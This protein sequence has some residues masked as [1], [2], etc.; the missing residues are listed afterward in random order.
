MQNN[1]TYSNNLSHGGNIWAKSLEWGIKPQHILDFSASINPL[2][3]SPMAIEAI[4]EYLP[5]LQHYPDPRAKEFKKALAQ[6]LSI[7]KKNLLLGNGSIELIYTISQALYKKRIIKLAPSFSEY[8]RGIINPNIKEISLEAEANFALPVDELV[9]NIVNNDLIFI[10]NPHNPSGKLFLKDELIDVLKRAKEIGA[11]LIIDEAF[12][13]FSVDRSQSM[14]DLINEYHNLIVLGSMT[15]FFAL[16]GLRLGY[17]VIA[18]EMKKLL[19]QRLP[20]WRV[21]T[22]ALVAGEASL[23]DKT[24]IKKSRD[25]INNEKGFL[26]NALSAINT[27]EIYDSDTNFILINAFKSGKS[28]EEM[29]EELK[30]SA[31]LIRNCSS[32]QGLTPNHFRIAVRRNHENIKLIDRLRCILQ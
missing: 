1:Y 2:G 13:D 12:M 21:N 20:P 25:L 28:S 8:G 18:N 4:L 22:L 17:A 10:N 9:K 30:E 29:Q 27:L 11:V 16:P 32:F 23:Y 19:E 24:Y 14:L 7:D 5:M 15:K 31:I 6:Y 3:P 26:Y